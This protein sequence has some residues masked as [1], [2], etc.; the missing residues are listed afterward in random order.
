MF[1]LVEERQIQV[2]EAHR[3][4]LDAK[5]G[6]TGRYRVDQPLPDHGAEGPWARA[7]YQDEEAERFR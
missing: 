2:G 5:L 7:A 6:G 4:Q 3:H 1:L